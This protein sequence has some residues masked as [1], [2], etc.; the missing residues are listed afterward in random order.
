MPGCAR[1]CGTGQG[2]IGAAGSVLPTTMPALRAGRSP[3]ESPAALVRRGP[4]RAATT[5]AQASRRVHGTEPAER[6]RTE[7]GV[8]EHTRE[9]LGGL[10]ER[11]ITSDDLIA[12]LDRLAALRGCPAVVRCDNG[13]ELAS[14]AMADWAGERTGLHFIP[15]GQPW[16]NGC[17]E[18]F[19][20]RSGRVPQHQHVLVTGAG[21]RGDQR[22]EGGRQP[23]PTTLRAR[24]PGP[25]GPRCS[26]HPPMSDS[27]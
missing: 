16:R 6:R 21:A 10:V 18:S 17:I 8:G 7:R 12:E 27:H 23:P 19:N 5:S 13:P 1:G 22:L 26:P 4:A 24:L 20:S 9:Y 15:P 2:T 25:S 11:N 14:V 3:Q